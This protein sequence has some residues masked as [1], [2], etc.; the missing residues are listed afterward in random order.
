MP[1]KLL[2]FLG[3]G[4]AIADLINVVQD[5]IPVLQMNLC[6]ERAVAEGDAVAPRVPPAAAPVIPHSVHDAIRNCPHLIDATDWNRGE[7]C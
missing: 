5:G 7:S 2:R 4:S 3:R 6:A 1:G